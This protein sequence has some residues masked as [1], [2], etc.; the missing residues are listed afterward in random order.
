MMF[1]KPQGKIDLEHRA[2]FELRGA[3]FRSRVIAAAEDGQLSILSPD[4]E[5]VQVRRLPTKVRAVSL[6]PS[7][8]RLAWVDGKTG[9]LT[10]QD[11]HGSRLLEIAPPEVRE[12]T[13]TWIER[14]FDDCFYS[15]DGQFLW[16][17]APL[18]SE[19][20]VVQLH[21]AET[22]ATI[23]RAALKDPFGGSSCSFHP[24]RRPD[25]TSLWLAAGQD[26][27]QV[28]WLK[29][30]RGGFS[31]TL[32]AKLRNT[33]PPIFSPNGEQILV[34]ND[35]NAICKFQFPAMQQVASPLE[36][37]DEDD[38]FSTSLCYLTDRHALAGTNE[39]RIFLLDTVQMRVEAEV[40][41]E[42][43]EPRPI[44][45]YYPSLAKERGLGTDISY[46]ARL[47]DVIVFVY[48]RD[49]GMDLAG[50]KDSLLWLPI[51]RWE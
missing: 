46:F 27:Q 48:R 26:G 32:E 25:L 5:E 51:K 29:R 44:G 47:G 20:V 31:C 30:T 1:L 19:D 6:H 18:N 21:E 40:S 41:V 13:P 4:L 42:G 3:P 10:V 35:L 38:P 14:G 8:Q 36:S 16:T 45:E 11:S 34:V 23:A 17:I 15:E 37:G 24:T 7:D 9:S 22:G 12:M 33:I 2:Y 28:Y 43:H 50:W 49:G 39:Q